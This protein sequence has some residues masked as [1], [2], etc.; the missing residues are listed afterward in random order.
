MKGIFFVATDELVISQDCPF[1]IQID[2]DIFTHSEA[3]QKILIIQ[4]KMSSFIGPR[5][6]LIDID[7]ILL[8]LGPLN[9][10]KLSK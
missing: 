8:Q 10:H 2:K 1:Q 5:M 6:A 7:S 3:H 9:G 4:Y